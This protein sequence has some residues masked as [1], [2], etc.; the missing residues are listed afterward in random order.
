MEIQGKVHTKVEVNPVDVIE[1][2]I[3]RFLNGDKYDNWINSE[4]GKH[5]LMHSRSEYHN[6]V[7]HDVVCELTQEDVDLVMKRQV[8]VALAQLFETREINSAIKE[9]IKKYV[10][11][12]IDKA[13]RDIT[14]E[15]IKETYE[16]SMREIM[17]AKIR[18]RLKGL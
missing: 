13:V 7:E 1:G 2:L 18:L 12:V 4:N 11:E 6:R 10:P 5:F 15:Q 14:T 17:D 16:S 8:R 3:T 9:Y